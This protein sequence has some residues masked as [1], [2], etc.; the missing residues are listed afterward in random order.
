M[1]EVLI[2]LVQQFPA[3]GNKQDSQYKDQ[4]YKDVK[5]VEIANIFLSS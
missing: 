2:D 1:G 4:T 3:L 5:W